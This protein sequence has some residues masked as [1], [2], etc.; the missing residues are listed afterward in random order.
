MYHAIESN[1]AP[2]FLT[3]TLI[4]EDGTEFAWEF[5]DPVRLVE[6]CLEHSFGLRELYVKTLRDHP[7][8]WN[9]V[10]GYDEFTPGS[11]FNFHNQRKSMV[12]GFNMVELGPTILEHDDTW[13]VPIVLPSRVFEDI[14]GGW[15]QPLRKLW[16]R[17]HYH[18]ASLAKLGFAFSHGGHSYIIRC[19]V[20][21]MLTDGDGHK[22]GLEW[23]GAGGMRPS[24][25]HGSVWRKDS[26]MTDDHNVEIT[27]S[28]HTKLIAHSHDSLN[29]CA[30]AALQ[31]H[32]DYHAGA[33]RMKEKFQEKEKAK[34]TSKAEAIINL[35][36]GSMDKFSYVVGDRRAERALPR[37]L[38]GSMRDVV[39]NL[40][41]LK[42][43]CRAFLK[44]TANE[45]PTL[46]PKDL[47]KTINE[48][49]KIAVYANKLLTSAPPAILGGVGSS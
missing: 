8:P 47:K 21:D 27:C 28:D 43:R 37:D 42:S 25:V 9:L 38:L 23:V 33:I 20:S 34:E 36:D 35:V 15:S 30:Q 7:Q 44:G 39:D 10:L 45:L 3:E 13:F 22:I 16:R 4:L 17:L 40:Q 31:A 6:Q 46:S 18:P 14:A 19:S 1:A 11:K 26:R 41:S 48:G 49:L 2:L 32:L 5:F 29:E 12:L 24:L